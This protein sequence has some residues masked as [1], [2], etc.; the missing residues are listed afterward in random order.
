MLLFLLLI[1]Y[2][3]KS[4]PAWVVIILIVIMLIGPSG[5]KK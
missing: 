5:T 3:F 1:E 4:L 2:L